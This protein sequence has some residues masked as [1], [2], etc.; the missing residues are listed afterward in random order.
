MALAEWVRGSSLNSLPVQLFELSW[1]GS[2]ASPFWQVRSTPSPQL[3]LGTGISIQ[4]SNS[5]RPPL[6]HTTTKQLL[7]CNSTL[8]MFSKLHYICSFY[9]IFS[10]FWHSL[11]ECHIMYQRTSLHYCTYHH[12]STSTCF[13]LAIYTNNNNDNVNTKKNITFNNKNENMDLSIYTC[14][15]NC[16]WIR[17]RSLS[18]TFGRWLQWDLAVLMWASCI[19]ASPTW[20]QRATASCNSICFWFCSL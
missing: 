20:S 13:F 19:Q 17:W 10:A 16:H 11:Y 4:H 2:L 12:F 15:G 1:T 7:F 8:A 5:R 18:C 9:D 14:Y 3:I 6:K